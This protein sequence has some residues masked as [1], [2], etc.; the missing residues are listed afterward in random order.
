V[1][2]DGDGEHIE[3]GVCK[4]CDRRIR[5]CRLKEDGRAQNVSVD[6]EPKP[7]GQVFVRSDGFSALPVDV[8]D[9][10][11]HNRP[12]LLGR[13]YYIGYRSTRTVIGALRQGRDTSGWDVQKERL[14]RAK[15]DLEASRR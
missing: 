1:V 6:P 14:R 11:I 13:R 5:W 15:L 9:I 8:V 10:E 12:E 4:A 3:T 7:M 2:D